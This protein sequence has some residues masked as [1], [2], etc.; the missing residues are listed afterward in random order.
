MFQNCLQP[1]PYKPL[2]QLVALP[3]SRRQPASLFSALAEVH[4]KSSDALALFDDQS[5]S[6]FTTEVC[7]DPLKEDAKPQAAL[8]QKLYVDQ[9]PDKPREE[10]THL[11]ATALQ[12]GKTLAD[13]GKV[14][15]I[16]VAK[17]GKLWFLDHLPK[18]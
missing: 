3:F 9:S 16:E 11:H 5:G 7:P 10:T 13:Y 17:R 4:Q 14:A 6:S 18:D 2:F 1:R 12:Y 8:C 15:L